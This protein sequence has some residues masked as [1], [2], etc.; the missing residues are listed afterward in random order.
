MDPTLLTKVLAGT[1]GLACIM[2]L[3]LA[4]KVDGPTAASAV[5]TITGVFLGSAAVL[6]GA[7]AIAGAINRKSA[8][9]V[10]A[11]PA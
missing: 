8:P 1:V 3:A 10:K 7:Q 9:E 2:V 11:P 5:Q 4:G 6:G